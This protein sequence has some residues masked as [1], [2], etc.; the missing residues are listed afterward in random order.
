MAPSRTCRNPPTARCAEQKRADAQVG[1]EKKHPSVDEARDA[2]PVHPS[3]VVRAQ[4]QE[5]LAKWR[6]EPAP[7]LDHIDNVLRQVS[8]IPLKTIDVQSD[9]EPLK[10]IASSLANKAPG[11]DTWKARGLSRMPLEFW[12]LVSV[13]WQHV[14]IHG[15]VPRIWRHAKVG[16]IRNKGPQNSARYTDSNHFSSGAQ[17]R[18]SHRGP[19]DVAGYFDSM[20]V[21]AM[22]KGFFC[23]WEHR[24]N[25]CP[26]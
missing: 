16:L 22:R 25:Y 1:F 23:G 19:M 2:G 8:Q 17:R 18:S 3:R 15:Q 26:S 5:W 13:L 14:W 6:S 24:H 4:A 20:N 10:A 11:P 12:H 9:A 21:P 7:H